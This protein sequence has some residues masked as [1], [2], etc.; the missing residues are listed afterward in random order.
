VVESTP[1]E[2]IRPFLAKTIVE[3]GWGL[4]EMK[5]L[6]LSLEEVFVHLVTEEGKE[7]Q[8]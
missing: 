8:P 1:E 4:K 3:A 2:N 7:A 5:S 6:D